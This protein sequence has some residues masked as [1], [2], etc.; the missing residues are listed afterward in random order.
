MLRH[1]LLSYLQTVKRYT[2][3]CLWDLRKPQQLLWRLQSFSVWRCAVWQ[4]PIIWRSMSKWVGKTGI[5]VGSKSTGTRSLSRP[6]GEGFCQ[7]LESPWITAHCATLHKTVFFV[8]T[9]FC[10]CCTP[11]NVPKETV[12]WKLDLFP[13]SGESVGS[14]Y[15]CGFH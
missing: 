1:F 12:F 10:W 6:V 13:S 8:I 14:S 11:S 3:C 5:D 2:M 4:I 9:E 7:Y 15:F